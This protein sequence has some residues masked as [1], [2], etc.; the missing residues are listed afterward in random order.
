PVVATRV[1]GIPELMKDSETGFLVEKG[2]P[3]ELI[4]KIT[5]LLGDIEKSKDMGRAGK[6]FVTENFSWD[7]ISKKFLQIINEHIG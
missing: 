5:I 4:D 1:G 6:K 7:V 3:H 2:N